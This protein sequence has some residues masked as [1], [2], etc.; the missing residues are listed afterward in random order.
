[1]SL[2]LPQNAA[3]RKHRPSADHQGSGRAVYGRPG[4]DS[5]RGETGEGIP[6]VRRCEK[7][8]PVAL[9]VNSRQLT[10]VVIVTLGGRNFG[11]DWGQLV[12]HDGWVSDTLR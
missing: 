11:S 10:R 3:D 7:R 9:W 12:I 8:F 4:Q 5:A 6:P 1:M 2:L